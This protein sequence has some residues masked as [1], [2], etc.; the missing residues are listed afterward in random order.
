MYKYD[1]T[2]SIFYPIN[3]ENSYQFL[4]TYTTAKKDQ[5][6]TINTLIDFNREL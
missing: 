6:K 1:F 3:N 5:L 4:H 2:D